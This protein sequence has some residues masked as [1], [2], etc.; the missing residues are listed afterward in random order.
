MKTYHIQITF[1]TDD[2][3]AFPNFLHTLIKSIEHKTFAVIRS[4]RTVQV[5]REISFVNDTSSKADTAAP[6]IM[7]RKEQ[8]VPESVIASSVFFVGLAQSSSC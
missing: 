7:H 6:D 8:T 4:F 5:F 1:N 3:P 2:F